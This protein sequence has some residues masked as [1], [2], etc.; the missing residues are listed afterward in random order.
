MKIT[1]SFVQNLETGM[2]FA[3]TDGMKRVANSIMWDK[4]MASRSS[5][6]RTEL[7]YF[8]LETARLED[9][10]LAGEVR[11]DDMASKFMTIENRRTGAGLRL[12]KE[13]IEDN[14]MAS[15]APALDYAK[16]WA[17]QIGGASVYY[18]QQKMFE[19]ITNGES[20]S[21]DATVY[22]GLAFFSLVHPINPVVGA[23]AGTY[24]NLIASKPID[25]SQTLAVAQANLASVLGTIA[26][27][28]M[29][30][31]IRRFLK[32]TKLL[33]SV[34]IA[35]RVSEMLTA[36]FAGSTDN[37]GYTSLGIEPIACPE[38]TGTNWYLA[39]E[40]TPGEGGGFIFQQR[41][42]YALNTFAPESSPQLMSR[43]EFNYDFSGR[44]AIAYG[45]PYLFVKVKAGA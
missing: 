23:S 12:R 1:P 42:A 28:T 21:T 38:L 5:S 6:T 36:R 43:K 13:E 39:C 45:H 27:Y 9:Q 30:N 17:D 7:I 26:A 19:L 15:G 11:R 37:I 31:G 25:F 40:P 16:Q 10:G 29:P 34:E 22:D 24:A 33:H 35:P 41:E 32:P 4:V 20:V 3:I 2:Q 14:I 44:N 8:L 18:P